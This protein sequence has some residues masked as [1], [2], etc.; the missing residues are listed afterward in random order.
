MG[1]K[2]WKLVSIRVLYTENFLS[3]YDKY[4]PEDD[5]RCNSPEFVRDKCTEL[6]HIQSS[7]WAWGQ[8]RHCLSLA[9]LHG[10]DNTR[11]QTGR[12][13]EGEIQFEE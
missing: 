11:L 10:N 3:V 13:R 6:Q 8:C 2:C 9:A 5:S 7:V 12:H 1:T 4:S